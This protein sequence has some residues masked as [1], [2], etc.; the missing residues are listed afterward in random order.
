MHIVLLALAVLALVLY[1]Q[2]R[3]RPVDQRRMCGFP[4]VLAVVALIQ[5]GLIDKVHPALNVALLAVEAV[6]AVGFVAAGSAAGITLV[7]GGIPL[8]LRV[9][10]LAQ[11]AVVSARA[12]RLG[13]PASV[14]FVP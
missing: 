10:L 12:R 2:L 3:T 11:S 7:A 1:G 9:S 6:A 8:F 5:G 13:G 14:S 4:L